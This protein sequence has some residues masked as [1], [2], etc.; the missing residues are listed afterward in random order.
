LGCRVCCSAD[1]LELVDEG[2]VFE[3]GRAELSVEGNG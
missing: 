1:R 3:L 2:R